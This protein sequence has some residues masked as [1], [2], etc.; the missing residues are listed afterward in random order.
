MLHIIL[1]ILQILLWI[2]LGLLGL[3]VLLLVI[4]LVAPVRYRAD[5][6]VYDNTSVAARIT[7]LILSVRI[8]Y[9]RNNKVKDTAIRV[10]GFKFKKKSD[11]ESKEE[12][13]DDKEDAL[14]FDDEADNDVKMSDAQLKSEDMNN[15]KELSDN[16]DTDE[17]LPVG[18]DKTNTENPARVLEDERETDSS[19]CNEKA[20]A[21]DKKANK[22]SKKKRADK[23]E[24]T[25]GNEAKADVLKKKL[26]HFKRFWDLPCTVKTREYLK[27]YIPGLIRHIGPRSIKG[28][29]RYGMDEPCKTGQL[30][31]YLSLMPFVYQEDFLLEPD[32]YNKVLEGEIKVKGHL[33]LGYILRILLNHNIWKTIKTAKKI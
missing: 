6:A 21:H 15:N 28:H 31:G 2:L 9:D 23:T 3:V 27:G 29:I 25:S 1:L 10:L 5:V 17:Y 32:F 16:N 22:S 12:F 18:E 26:K 11:S 8:N 33:Q 4:I 20:G 14:L 30:T 19:P 24:K 13:F 7:Y